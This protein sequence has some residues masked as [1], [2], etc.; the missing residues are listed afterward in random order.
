MTNAT[1]TPKQEQVLAL[2]GQDKTVQ[3]IAKKLKISPSGVYGH[4][5]RMREAGIEIPGDSNSGRGAQVTPLAEVLSNGDSSGSVTFGSTPDVT[6]R[7]FIESAIGT[8]KARLEIMNEETDKIL[9]RK[10]EL[11]AEKTRTVGEIEKYDR[12]LEALGA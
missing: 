7:E 6:V 4:M 10:A 12:A 8:E 2:L 9:T 3:Q 5:R 1:L 11:D